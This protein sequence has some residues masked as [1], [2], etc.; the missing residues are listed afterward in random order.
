[1]K[2]SGIENETI[3]AD[4]DRDR[5]PLMIRHTSMR[6]R[7]FFPGFARR[8]RI[9]PTSELL[10]GRSLV[11]VRGC[12]IVCGDAAGL[13]MAAAALTVMDI[14][15]WATV[16]RKTQNN[17]HLCS[18]KRWLKSSKRSQNSLLVPVPKVSGVEK[19]LN[20]EWGDWYRARSR[21]NRESGDKASLCN[22]FFDLYRLSLQCVLFKFL[23]QLKI[24]LVF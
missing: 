9:N 7:V 22:G 23:S 15:Y 24:S 10:W 6:W 1:M 18:L 19:N 20:W 4:W 2:S 21:R 8:I 12:G 13:K 16:Y 17:M 11:R 5:A 14:L 3:S